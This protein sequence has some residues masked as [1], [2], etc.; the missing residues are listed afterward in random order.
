[1]AISFIE[2]RTLL[3]TGTFRERVIQAIL[4]AA[5]A[6]QNEDPNT[7]NHAS[8]VQLAYAVVMNPAGMEQR[9]SE[10]LS[11]QM[12]SAEPTDADIS[13]AVSAIWNAVAL[14]MFHAE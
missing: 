14:S 4:T 3:K 12:T 1:M 10:I 13:N 9:F 11:T 2:Q 7:P 8:R 5:L 6:I